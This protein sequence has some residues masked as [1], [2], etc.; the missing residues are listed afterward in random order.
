[1]SLF[2]AIDSVTLY[3]GGGVFRWRRTSVNAHNTEAR[4]RDLETLI[5]NANCC[6]LHT[7][8][9]QVKGGHFNSSSRQ[10]GRKEARQ[11][12]GL[13]LWLINGAHWLNIQRRPKNHAV[14]TNA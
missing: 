14:S 2:S 9:L 13:S 3:G 11:A 8:A 1:M 7:E 10:A 4:W 5:A 12:E 6:E